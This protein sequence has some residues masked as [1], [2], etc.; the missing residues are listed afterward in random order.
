LVCIDSIDKKILSL[1]T[2][3][4]TFSKELSIFA[5]LPNP[6]IAMEY[7]ELGVDDY[8]IDK[9]YTPTCIKCRIFKLLN[10]DRR[11]RKVYSDIAINKE[12]STVNIKDVSIK[13]T[14]SECTLINYMLE[15]SGTCDIGTYITYQRVCFNKVVK[16]ECIVMLVSRL[17]RKI[18]SISGYNPIKKRYKYG[19]Y[20]DS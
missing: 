4:K 16:R 2:N 10:M 20:L 12:S 6:D 1:I 15:N 8:V 17:R 14:P 9:L 19:Y 11:K 5:I 3:L 18:K 13:L 7:S